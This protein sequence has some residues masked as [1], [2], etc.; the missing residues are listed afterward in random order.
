[1]RRKKASGNLQFAFFFFVLLAGTIFISF[2]FR[3]FF[4]LKETKFDGSSHFTLK[5]NG[6]K[7]VQYL[8]FSPQTSNIGILTFQNYPAPY[9]IPTDAKTKTDLTFDQKNLNLSLF[10]AFFD[11]KN[12][13]EI[14]S[15]DIFRLML[16]S[17]TV[18]ENSIKQMEISNETNK[19]LVDS[20]ISNF[21]ADP[22]IQEEKLNIEVINATEVYGLGNRLA[23]LVSNTGANVVLVSTGDFKKES[24]I[25]YFEPSYTVD[26]LSKILKF[27]K[28]KL[29]QEGL[30]NVRIIVGR[31]YV[32][33][34]Q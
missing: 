28:V 21:F 17:A 2:L 25:E 10:K 23:N 26:K 15:V 14:N 22:K 16:F 5:L 24:A 32:N 8:S 34:E 33:L 11:F 9:E 18:R 20:T 19:V 27:K 13:K 29:N 3:S 6:P 31:E 4:L 7:S 12:Q 1:M 30:A